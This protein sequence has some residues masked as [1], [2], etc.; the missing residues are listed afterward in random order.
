[1]IGRTARLDRNG[2]YSIIVRENIED[3]ER[4]AAKNRSKPI[5]DS[6]S[7]LNQR[8]IE[9]TQEYLRHLRARYD[10]RTVKR[11]IALILCMQSN[12]I[13][14]KDNDVFERCKLFVTGRV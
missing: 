10:E 6:S 14:L 11:W 3:F 12:N 1:M 5:I 2:S 7:L 4:Q 8:K 9:I 13:D